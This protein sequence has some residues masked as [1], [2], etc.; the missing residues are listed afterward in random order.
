VANETLIQ[1]VKQIVARA[2]SGDLD[3]AYAGYRA[4]FES[5]DFAGYRVEERR[6]ALRLMVTL[7]GAPKPA[8]EAMIGAHRAAATS[9]G[10]MVTEHGE[11]GD[12]ELLGIC[13]VV[14]GDTQQASSVFR[15]G[16]AIERKRNADSNLCGALLKRIS[17]I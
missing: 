10:A 13:H 15:S 16:L 14:M 11:S 5:A 3:G 6:Q 4:L 12:H 1:A 8:T 7:K 2:N 17:E 9:L